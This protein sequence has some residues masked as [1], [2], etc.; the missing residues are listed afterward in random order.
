MEEFIPPPVFKKERKA[1]L[2]KNSS[3]NHEKENRMEN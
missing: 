3:Y 1:E 2:V